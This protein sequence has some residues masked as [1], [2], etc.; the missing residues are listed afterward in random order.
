MDNLSPYR[1]PYAHLQFQ[2]QDRNNY[3]KTKDFLRSRKN[4]PVP[5]YKFLIKTLAMYIQQTVFLTLT[6]S[7]F[8]HPDLLYHNFLPFDRFA[9]VHTLPPYLPV[10]ARNTVYSYLI[11]MDAKSYSDNLS[12][13]RYLPEYS[14]YVFRSG[15]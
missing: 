5:I 8:P 14:R 3:A 12:L 4:V 15:K 6:N 7:P 9:I 1:T 10:A 2:G 13:K 11:K